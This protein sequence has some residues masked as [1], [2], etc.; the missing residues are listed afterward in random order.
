M[1]K[2]PANAKFRVFQLFCLKKGWHC[3]TLFPPYVPYLRWPKNNSPVNGM[4]V[5]SQLI[6]SNFFGSF[7]SRSINFLLICVNNSSI[8]LFVVDLFLL[9]YLLP[10]GVFSLTFAK[11]APS[12]PLFLCFSM[13]KYIFFKA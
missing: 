1:L 5:L 13:S 7:S 12:C 2:F 6:S 10:A 4:L 8:G 3:S 9:I 11:P